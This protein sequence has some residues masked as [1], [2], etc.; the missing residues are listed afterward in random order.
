MRLLRNKLVKK[1]AIDIEDLEFKLRDVLR[2]MESHNEHAASLTTFERFHG[3]LDY[4]GDLTKMIADFLMETAE[5]II[6]QSDTYSSL[7]D[8]FDGLQLKLVDS[9]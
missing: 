9:I 3:S 6:L 5:I 7:V 2:V 8:E 4:E 1:L